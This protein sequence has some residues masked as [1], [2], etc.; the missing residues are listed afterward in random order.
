MHW[1]S[2]TAVQVGAVWRLVYSQ[3]AEEDAP[4]PEEV[5]AS[6]QGIV[7]NADLPPF[8]ECIS[9]G[10]K[11]IKYIRQSVTLTAFSDSAFDA[12]GTNIAEVHT[13]FRRIMSNRYFTPKSEVPDVAAGIVLGEDIDPH[14]N[15]RRAAGTGYVHTADNQ[16]YYFEQQVKTP[17]TF[18]V[19]DIV[20]VQVSF[21]VLPLQ[22][23]KLKMSMILRSISLLDGSQTQVSDRP[24]VTL[25]R[26]VGYL[27]E[28]VSTTRAKFVRMEI[29]EKDSEEE[30]VAEGLGAKEMELD[31]VD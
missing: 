19:G 11:Q 21:A 3:V 31:K 28:E 25:K 2:Y 18:Q 4:G 15:L 16:V 5:V 22:E 20:E 7:C 30:E 12:V 23:G 17:V 8:R 6:L 29:N 13:L 14:G 24:R 26:R 10:S 27:E 1:N 9:T